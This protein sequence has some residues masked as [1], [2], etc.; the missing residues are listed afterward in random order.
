F[1]AGLAI[2]PQRLVVAG[3]QTVRRNR[4][5][6]RGCGSRSSG[7]D[8]PCAL[9]IAERHQQRVAVMPESDGKSDLDWEELR[10]RL[11]RAT[12]ALDGVRVPSREQ[13]R[14]RLEERAR[15]VIT[16]IVEARRQD[17]LVEA[18]VF[19]SAGE[20]YAIEARY[21]HS[22]APLG[23]MTMIPGASRVF[24]GLAN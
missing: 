13:I 2:L 19:S 22:V 17:D 24:S 3:C 7:G 10:A 9:S 5:A 15:Q 23:P 21:V 11:G 18:I 4:R 1:R 16:P 12:D 14:D 8:R 20:R 6:I